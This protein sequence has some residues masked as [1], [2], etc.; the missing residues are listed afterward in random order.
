[1]GFKNEDGSLDWAFVLAAGAAVSTVFVV[2]ALAY[3]L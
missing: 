2:F 3:G 1:M